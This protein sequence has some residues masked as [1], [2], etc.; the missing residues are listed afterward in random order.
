[1]FE[2]VMLIAFL[3]APVMMMLPAAAPVKVRK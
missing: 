3:A 1:M 2:I